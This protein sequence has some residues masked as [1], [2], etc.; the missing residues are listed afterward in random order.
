MMKKD[1]IQILLNRPILTT[2]Q[3]KFKSVNG[4]LSE[5]ICNEKNKCGLNKM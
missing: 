5:T 2:L 3:G 4:M 1:S